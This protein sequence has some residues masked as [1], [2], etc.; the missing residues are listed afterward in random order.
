MERSKALIEGVTQDLIAFLVEESGHPIEKAA[1]LVYDSEVFR[2][3][4]DVETGLY[5]ESSDY[6]STLLKD[7]LSSGQFMQ[8][9]V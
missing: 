2:K 3:L 1:N 7:E 4:S 8:E 9:E 6:V 5:R